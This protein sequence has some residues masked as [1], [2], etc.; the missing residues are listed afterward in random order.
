MLDNIL[1]KNI[2]LN[3]FERNYKDA[4]AFHHRAKQFSEEDQSPSI[5]FNVAS[6][7]LEQYLISICH[8]Y[9]APPWN[10]TYDFLMDV[11]EIVVDFP[12]ELNNEIR[13]IGKQ[14]HEYLCSLEPYTGNFPESSDASKILAICDKISRTFDQSRISSI[15][16]IKKIS[17]GIL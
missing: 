9:G 17:G 14:S 5:I 16:A 4:K 2:D 11:V 12:K 7:A 8:L 1:L 3:S 15:R 6:I 13:S 10:H